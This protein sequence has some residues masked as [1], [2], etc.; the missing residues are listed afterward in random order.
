[1]SS[2]KLGSILKTELDTLIRQ[3]RIKTVIIK[4][5]LATP[6]I[7]FSVIID[8]PIDMSEGSKLI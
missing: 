3:V 1:M 5:G 2:F 6:Q 7:A 8:R 4:Y